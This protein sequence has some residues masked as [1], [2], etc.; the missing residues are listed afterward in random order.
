ML[1]E[2]FPIEVELNNY[3]F[4][5]NNQGKVEY[6]RPSVKINNLIVTKEDGS[7]IP[8]DG[9]DEGTK[10]KI[11][12]E[13]N[14]DRGNVLQVSPGT[15]QNGKVI[16]ITQGNEKQVIFTITSHVEGKTYEDSKTIS[17]ESYYKKLIIGE[18]VK[19]GDFVNYSAGNWTDE[20]IAKLGNLYSESSISYGEEYYYKF[21]GFGINDGKITS[22]DYT[23]HFSGYLGGSN[24]YSN[25]W[26][27]LSKNTDGTVNI[28][29][30]GTPEGF[31][32]KDKPDVAVN[33]FLNTRD[34]SMYED[35]STNSV[36][37]SYAVKDSARMV[38]YKDISNLMDSNIVLIGTHYFL[39][40]KQ[41]EISIY[42]VRGDTGKYG[43][44]QVD[45]G[46]RPVVTLKAEI[47]VKAKDGQTTHITPETAW[48]LE[49]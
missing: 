33:I 21:G 34:W 24:I 28:I 20:D 22:K 1:K 41:S 29:H 12:F 17:V 47:I 42:C 5:V 43:T 32:Y 8:N 39:P 36:S 3:L 40:E 6:S 26:R 14:I 15:I 2:E 11:E 38:N 45:M 35:C 31:V 44:N 46:I 10:L 23:A 27:V 30:A 48:E 7:I 4:I 18:T 37:S 16:Y 13:V 49:L 9:V 25:G 19:I